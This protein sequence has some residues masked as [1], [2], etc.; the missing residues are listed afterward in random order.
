[1]DDKAPR[2]KNLVVV[3]HIIQRKEDPQYS[4]VSIF[5]IFQKINLQ[6]IKLISKSLV[7]LKKKTFKKIVTFGFF[8][9]TYCVDAL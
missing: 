1:M 2:S 8:G 4:P 3:V 6:L 7:F 5:I 9:S